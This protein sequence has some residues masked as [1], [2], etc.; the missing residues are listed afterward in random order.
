MWR[1]NPKDYIVEA[2]SVHTA[3][4]YITDLYEL[5]LLWYTCPNVNV[6]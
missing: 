1:N 4:V 3:S 2:Q 5:R 6:T